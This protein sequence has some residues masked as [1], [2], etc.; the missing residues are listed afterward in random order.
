MKKIIAFTIILFFALTTAFAQIPR[1]LIAAGNKVF[2][3]EPDKTVSWIYKAKEGG[4]YDAWPLETGNVLFSTRCGVYEVTPQKKIVWE[5]IVENN[6]SNEIESCQPISNGNVLIVDA[7]NNRLIELNQAKEVV[8]E[9]PLPS[10]SENVHWRYR[11]GRKNKRGNYLIAMLPDK[12]IEVDKR[13]K[14]HREIDLKRYGETQGQGMLHSFDVLELDDG[15][16]LVSTGFDGRWLEIDAE[17]NLVWEFSKNTHPDIEICFA[18]GAEQ[19]ENG[20]FILCNADYHTTDPK[21]QKVQLLELTPDNK[22]VNR[23]LF[24]DLAQFIEL[25]K[26]KNKKMNYIHL[27]GAKTF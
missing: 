25:N 10:K 17:G 9:I 13:G 27:I 14:L 4:L 7:G 12:I 22:I 3:L 23:I 15:N 2:V 11:L 5:Y 24:D 8:V 6:S 26:E 16:L 18:G 21:Q 20:N 19:L 1:M